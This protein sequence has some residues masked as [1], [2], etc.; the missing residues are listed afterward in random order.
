[1]IAIILGRRACLRLETNR[2]PSLGRETIMGERHMPRVFPLVV[3]IALACR[4]S[5]ASGT[6]AFDTRLS[7]SAMAASGWAPRTW[8]E[9]RFNIVRWMT[10]PR[11]GHF[12]AFEQPH[13]VVDDGGAFV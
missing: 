2:V 11:G 9:P 1:M 4:A 3:V 13:Q 7:R 12:A 10:M 8:L 6:R 5:P